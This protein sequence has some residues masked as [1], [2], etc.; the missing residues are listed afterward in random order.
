MQRT[1]STFRD[2]SGA[3]H[4]RKFG[5]LSIRGILT[6]TWPY[7]RPPV[8]HTTGKPM[9]N[10]KLSSLCR[11]LL[12]VFNLMVYIH[13]MFNWQLSKQGIRWPESHARLRAQVPTHRGHVFLSFS[14]TSYW[15]LIDRR[16]KF[17]F[18]SHMVLPYIKFI[19]VLCNDLKSI[20]WSKFKMH[21]L[22][23]PP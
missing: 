8:L 17:T 7:V 14:L 18:F 11:S 3:Q 10:V 15:L 22:E 5:N 21:K 16:F 19:A 6:I 1:L 4:L 12:P 20:V 23:L 9:W 2:D 13:I